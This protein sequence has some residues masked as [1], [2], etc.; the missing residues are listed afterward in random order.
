MHKAIIDKSQEGHDTI[1]D[2]LAKHQ[3]KFP[4]EG[5]TAQ[6][7]LGTLTDTIFA[8][9]LIIKLGKDNGSGSTNFWHILM[10]SP[11]T[12]LARYL[13]FA[14]LI[15]SLDFTSI[16]GAP[17]IQEPFLCRHCKGVDHPTGM[18]PYFKIKGWH[19]KPKPTSK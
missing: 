16:Y 6:V 13:Y 14:K 10:D 19:N 9:R 17:F 18:C 7:V 2:F 8:H 1:L 5:I 12:D 15:M 4:V 3:N 11:V